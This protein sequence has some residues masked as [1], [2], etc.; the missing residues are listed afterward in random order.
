MKPFLAKAASLRLF[1][2]VS[3]RSLRLRLRVS[4]VTGTELCARVVLGTTWWVH[5]RRAL[6]WCAL[7]WCALTWRADVAWG[8]RD[9]CAD[10]ARRWAN[11]LKFGQR[12]VDLERLGDGRATLWADL[13]V[14][15]V[16]TRQRAVDSQRLTAK[17]HS[18]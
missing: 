1:L 14:T 6:T 7:T 15:E 3:S 2:A 8:R 9:L 11:L 13:V 12:A 4:T 16:E 5:C 17:L 10:V 18:V